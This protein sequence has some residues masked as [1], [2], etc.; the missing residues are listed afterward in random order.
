MGL[1]WSE[2]VEI[3]RRFAKHAGHSDGSALGGVFDLI[4][5]PDAVLAF[6]DGRGERE[7]VVDADI[8][9]T[10]R[11]IETGLFACERREL[12]APPPPPAP[13]PGPGAP[14]TY[15]FGPELTPEQ[16]ASVR[17]GLDAGAR[18]Y[19]AVLGREL[20]PVG[21]WAYADLESMIRA[22]SSG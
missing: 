13:S 9:G 6:I 17:R 12:P 4:V 7:I 19:R 22:Y 20:P 5:P 18:Y 10:P 8:V 14:A 2:D 11:L 1:S 15:V 16:Q 21:V 3:A